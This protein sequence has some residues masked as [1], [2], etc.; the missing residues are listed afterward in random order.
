MDY[1]LDI[2]YDPIHL[3]NMLA[4][5][6]EK[7]PCYHGLFNQIKQEYCSSRYMIYDGIFNSKYH[8]SD[9]EVYLVNTLDYPVYSYNIEKVKSAYRTIYSLF[10]R[11]A[12]FLNEYFSLGIAKDRVSFGAVWRKNS[13]LHEIAASNYLLSALHWIKKDLYKNS[14]SEY[15]EY[16]DPILHRTYEIRNVMEHRYLKILDNSFHID[17]KQDIDN[18]AFVITIE[19]FHELAIN[20][21]RTC[22]EAI[23]LLVMA[24]NIEEKRKYEELG[25]K[26]IPSISLSSYD[27]EWKF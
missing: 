20:L 21:L 6:E 16:I 10:D 7:H 13:R 12:F 11:I 27:D 4:S 23:I 24:I 1:S 25:E 9:A 2:S 15:K 22:R 17:D 26:F 19:E 14:V 8:F 5:F 3:P 18:L